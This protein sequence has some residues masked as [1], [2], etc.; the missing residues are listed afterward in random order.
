MVLQNLRELKPIFK[1]AFDQTLRVAKFFCCLHVTN[2]Y[3]CS[4]AIAQ[5]PSM[6]PTFNLTG[7]VVLV[8][9]LSRRFGNMEV[10]DVVLIRSPAEPRKVIIKRI[11]GVAGDAVSYSM[12]GDNG[13]ATVVV[14]KGHIWI[15]GD[16]KPSSRDSRMYGPV[17]YGLLQGKVRCVVWP[18]RDFGLVGKAVP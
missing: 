1:E 18:P 14:P 5:G 3:L 9:R 11:V 2:T 10:G 17:P 13:E 6:L 16:N 15:E 7:N 12:N 8:E 4:F